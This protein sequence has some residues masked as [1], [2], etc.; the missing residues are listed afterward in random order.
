MGGKSSAPAAPDYGPIA[1]SDTYQAQLEY[2]VAENQLQF[3][4]DQFNQVWPYAQSYLQQQ[5]ASSAAQTQQA[6]TSQQYYDSTYKPIESQFATQA[7]N[8]NTPANANQQAGGAMADVAST[9]DANRAASLSSLESYGIDPSQTRYGA[10]DLGTRISQAAATA[11]AGTQ[12][13]LNT[14][15]TG[16]ALEGDAINTGRGYASTVANDYTTATNAGMAGINAANS[17]TTTGVNAMGSPSSYFGLGN[18]SNANAAGAMNMGY[19]NQL[20]G[21]Q[22]SAQQSEAAWGGIGSLVGAGIGVAGMAM[23]M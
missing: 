9:F 3:G 23:M 15:A 19:Q 13:R 12:S 21:A 5:T 18:S 16:M 1:Q 4:K 17:T 6:Q 22:F 2:N 11:A 10:L 7:I 14:Q 20:S 8:Y